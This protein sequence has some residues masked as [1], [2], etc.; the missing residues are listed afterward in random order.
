MSMYLCVS[1]VTTRTQ[2]SGKIV[3]LVVDAL[4]VVM[5]RLEASKHKAELQL[6]NTGG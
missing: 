4:W 3:Y 2:R 5:K 1:F 6:L